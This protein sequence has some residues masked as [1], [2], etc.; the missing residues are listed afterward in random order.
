METAQPTPD[1]ASHEIGRRDPPEPVD[2]LHELGA[3]IRSEDWPR[4]L[5]VAVAVWRAT[6]APELADLVDRVAARCRTLAPPRRDLHAWWM[7]HARRPHDPVVASALLDHVAT[8]LRASDPSWSTIVARWPDHPILRAIGDETWGSSF[9]WLDRFAAIATWPDDP[10]VARVLAGW[11]TSHVIYVAP[12]LYE[13]TYRLV[14]DRLAALADARVLPRLDAALAQPST[15]RTTWEHAQRRLVAHARSAI[16]RAAAPTP[17][18]RARVAALAALVAP[19]ERELLWQQ[20]GDRPDEVAPRIVLADV[21]SSAHD[22]RGELIA[23]QRAIMDEPTPTP[24]RDPRARRVRQLLA[25]EWDRW[26]G[27]LVPLIVRK[28]SEFWYGMLEVIVVGHSFTP[29][30]AWRA[31]RGHRELRTVHTVRPHVVP[32]DEYASFVMALEHLRTLQIDAHG[33]AAA[34]AAARARLAITRLEY[35]RVRSDRD[36]T[37]PP[38]RATFELLAGIAPDV[39]AI[40]LDVGTLG[41]QLR[42]VAATLPSLFARLEAIEVKASTGHGARWA[43]A[44]VA[45]LPLVR[46][47]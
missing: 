31:A 8:D 1:D 20:V 44:H 23:L 46:I 18:V 30:W 39:V 3:A 24:A 9:N 21:L 13:A 11:L 27:D 33:T 35:R 17:E 34:L 37:E 32:V 29:R 6:R 2:P 22:S 7:E 14:A 16:E 38:A 5:A 42:D 45:G 10:R 25:A 41:D 43:A 4:A 19:D 26:L 47:E 15:R 28:G 12:R 40:G 36:H